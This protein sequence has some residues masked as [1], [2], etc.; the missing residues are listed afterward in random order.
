MKSSYSFKATPRDTDYV[1][2]CR[3]NHQAR[4]VVVKTEGIGSLTFVPLYW[5]EHYKLVL[6]KLRPTARIN[7]PP[8]E[9]VP[10][11]IGREWV[12]FEGDQSKLLAPKVQTVVEV[13]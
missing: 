4:F 1:R 10:G 7:V 12:I 3:E 5:Q 8:K 2:I 13:Y 9:Q 11:R 6:E